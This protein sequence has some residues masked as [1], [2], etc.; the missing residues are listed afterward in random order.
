MHH[1]L[2]DPAT[3]R[4]CGVSPRP[5]KAASCAQESNP[6]LCKYEGF[7]HVFGC[8]YM[9]VFR[10]G[11]CMSFVAGLLLHVFRCGSLHVFRCMSLVACLLLRVFGCGTLVAVTC[12]SLVAGRCVSFV[13]CLLL[14]VFCCG[15]CVCLVAKDT[16]LLATPQGACSAQKRPAKDAPKI[17]LHFPNPRERT[18]TAR[19]RFSAPFAV[20]K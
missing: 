7:L 14:H 16:R 6:G 2:I 13:A 8:G 18:W 19:D 4:V 15:S 10:C 17:A 5:P 9:H 12:M 11:R 3:Q 20:V 1:S